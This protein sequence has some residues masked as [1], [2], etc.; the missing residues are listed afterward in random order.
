MTADDRAQRRGRLGAA[1]QEPFTA[2]VRLR[3]NRQSATD[4]DSFRSHVKRL[5]SAAHEEARRVGYRGDDIKLAIFAVVAFLD[6]SVLN[7]RHPAFVEWPRCP[8]QEELFGGHMGGETFFQ[9]LQSLL[10]TQESEDLADV[11]EVYQLC[12][13][14]GFQGRYA[15]ATN[16]LRS[17][18]AAT[19]EK[20]GRIRGTRGSLSPGWAPAKDEVIPV[21]RDGMLRPLGYTA[22]AMFAIGCVVSLVFWMLQQ[23]WVT[24]LRGLAGGGH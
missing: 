9:N 5:L 21:A 16:E 19:G 20:I 7:S 22:I 4:A 23:S 18:A 3:A 14:L 15:G 6:E 24:D 13:L 1:L 2:T 11:L 12:L 10:A 17:W 8:L